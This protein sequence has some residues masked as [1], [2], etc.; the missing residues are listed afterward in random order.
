MAPRGGRGLRGAQPE[1][2]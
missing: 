2:L 1:L